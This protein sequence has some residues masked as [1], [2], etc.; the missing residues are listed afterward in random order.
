MIKDLRDA[1]LVDAVPR[2]VAGQ[3]WVRALS[4]AVGVLHE[5]TLRYIDDSQIYT[6]L[7]TATEPVLDALAINWKVDWYDTGYSLEQKRRIIKTALT[8]RRLMGTVGAVKLQADAIYPGTMLEEWFEYGGQP[9]T[10][11][12]YINVADTTE[13]HPAIIYSPAEMER[14]LITAKRWSAHLESL[15]YMVRHTL[16]T[17]CRVDK[18]AYTVP[19]C[20]TIYC[21]VWWMPATLGYT[22]HHALLT[23]GQP[24]A[25]AVSPEFTGTL[26]VP[27]TVGYSV[28]G[29][30]E[31]QPATPQALNL[32]AHCR[33]RHSME[34]EKANGQYGKQNPLF[35]YQ[36]TAGY[37]IRAELHGSK[38]GVEAAE[39]FTAVPSAS[40]QDRCGTMP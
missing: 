29:A 12:L 24:G 26:P 30:V 39:A 20:G 8:V 3:D 10:F 19:E 15:S 34:T 16:A 7:D 35:M 25:F 13:E 37:S 14:R 17:G 2:V 33:R 11:R 6:S 1:R 22:A 28:C 38:G 36:G 32:Q 18:W 40:G 5:R 23:G 31:L 4:E 21:G 9:G 27:A